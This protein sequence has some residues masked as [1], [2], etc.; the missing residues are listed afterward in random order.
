V[1]EVTWGGQGALS[2]A[3]NESFLVDGAVAGW[4]RRAHNVSV[5][6]LADAGTVFSDVVYLFHSHLA[7]AKGHLSPFDQP[8]AAQEMLHQFLS[9]GFAVRVPRD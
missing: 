7:S 6:V 9:G 1:K 3:R 5:L 2:Q 4:L 8:R